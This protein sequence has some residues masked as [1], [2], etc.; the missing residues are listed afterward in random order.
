MQPHDYF[1][2]NGMYRLKVRLAGIEVDGEMDFELIDPSYTISAEVLKQ[3][4]PFEATATE[5][6]IRAIRNI[7]VAKP[8]EFATI[9]QCLNGLP[10]FYLGAHG[11]TEEH[12]RWVYYP[13]RNAP[14]PVGPV[15][16]RLAAAEAGGAIIASCNPGNYVLRETR[17]PVLYPSD[18]IHRES[19]LLWNHAAMVFAAPSALQDVNAADLITVFLDNLCADDIA[20]SDKSRVRD[21]ESWKRATRGEYNYW[22]NWARHSLSR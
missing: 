7:A 19:E 6:F 14:A 21:F 16:E 3:D 13:R 4:Y 18:T 15:E 8:R 12:S 2:D 1:D 5:W 17:F 10:L 22:K 20:H 9:L 11:N